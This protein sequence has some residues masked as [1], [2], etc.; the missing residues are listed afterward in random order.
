MPRA[1]NA[2][3]EIEYET[4]GDPD[5]PALLLVMGLGAQMIAWHDEFCGQ[6]VDAGHHVVR[7]DNRDVGLSTRTDGAPPDVAAMLGALA[8]GQQVDADHVPYTLTDMAADGVAVLDD[9]GI[10][11]AH[12]V[13]ASLGGMISQQMAI[14]H[15][16]RVRTLTSIMSTTGDPS[17]GRGT[18]QAMEALAAP[19]V[20]SREEYLDQAE[21]S[22]RTI[23]GPLFDPEETRR[24]AG[25][26]YDRSYH[27]IGAAFQLAAIF[28]TGDRT[29]GLRELSLPTLVVHGAVDPLIDVSGGHATAEA[30]PGADLLVL[31]E[32]GHDLPRPLWPMIVGAVSATTARDGRAPGSVGSGS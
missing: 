12:V 24:R 15:P 25:E 29:D 11:R 21:R 32:M 13:G 10:D 5:D 27:P 26:S 23:A 8:T 2:G 9:L 4:F 28:A 30:I 14:E 31:G 1:D 20:A 7:Y 19:P 6:L 17:V 18:P 3:V 22:W 16:D